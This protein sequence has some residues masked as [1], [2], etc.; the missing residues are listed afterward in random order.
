MSTTF[1]SHPVCEGVVLSPDFLSQT[2]TRM[3][4]GKPVTYHRHINGGG[5]VADSS[6]VPFDIR[7]PFDVTVGPDTR[8]INGDNLFGLQY[9]CGNVFHTIQVARLMT[10]FDKCELE[11]QRNH[12]L[13]W[14]RAERHY[15]T[16]SRRELGSVPWRLYY[17]ATDARDTVVAW[18]Y[19]KLA[20][21]ARLT[22]VM[23]A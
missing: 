10:E 4:H 16:R 14:C 20:K 17:K 18:R 9:L 12:C 11:M 22:G 2:M 5:W 3:L 21:V 23:A 6:L 13:L 1:N 7:I 15:R 8:I 19:A